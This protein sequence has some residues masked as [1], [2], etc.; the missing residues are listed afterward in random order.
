[1]RLRGKNMKLGLSILVFVL[2]MSFSFAQ[3]NAAPGCGPEKQKIQVTTTKN[4]APIQP[5]PGKALIYVVQDDS[6]YD[7]RPRPT[8][9]IGIDGAWIGAT[10]GS[11]F[12]RA[13]VEP[14]EHHMCASWQGFV[15]LGVASRE[16]ALHFTAEPGKSYYFRVRDRFIREHERANIDFMPLG[17]DEGQLLA[18]KAA[19]SSS[20]PK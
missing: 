15:G 9:R 10:Q 8:T 3:Q 14:G 2:G 7:S 11:S 18:S 12:L 20:V 5:D 19:L 4:Y 6:Q 17:S 1:M 13:A 16:A